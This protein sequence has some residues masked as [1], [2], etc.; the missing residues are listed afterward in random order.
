MVRPWAVSSRWAS[1][2]E[3][4]NRQNFYFSFEQLF[5][6][7]S[8]IQCAIRACLLLHWLYSFIIVFA[9]TGRSHGWTKII[10]K[11]RIQVSF[12]SFVSLNFSYIFF[13]FR[14]TE[15]IDSI[16]SITFHEC[17]ILWKYKMHQ[18]G[19][20][21]HTK[22]KIRVKKNEL[23]IENLMPLSFSTR[24]FNMCT[25]HIVQYIEHNDNFNITNY[26]TCTVAIVNA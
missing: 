24:H 13:S 15:F 26:F 20:R 25:L 6:K 18:P 2:I 7:F 3:P 1:I 5:L 10:I 22:Y 17:T 11:Y 4:I 9:F 21:T 14:P 16:Q 23:K 19:H 8:R 12:E